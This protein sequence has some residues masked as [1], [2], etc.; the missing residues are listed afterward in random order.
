MKFGLALL[1][2]LSLSMS[3]W[4]DVRPILK[5]TIETLKFDNCTEKMGHVDA[6][7]ASLKPSDYQSELKQSGPELLGVELWDF[8]IKVHTLLREFHQKG[9]LARDCANAYRGALRAIRYVE[10]L[11][12]EHQ[13]RINGGEFPSNAFV[14]GN[15]HVKR[16]PKFKDFDMI[17][18]LKSGDV[19][20][21]RG[22]AYTSAAIAS[23]GEFDT[24]FSHMSLVYIDADK[25]VWTVEA[26]IEVGSF[27]RPIEDH[28]KDNNFRTM[29][30]RFDDEKLAAKAAELMFIKVRDASKKTGNILYDFGFDMKENNS[31]FCSEIVSYGFSLASD[32]KLQIPLYTSRLMLRKPS[33][34]KNLGITEDESFIPADI[35][36]DPRFQII[37]EWRDAARVQDNHEKDAILHA[38]F[39][40]ADEFDYRM[41]QGSS[42]TSR[43]Y[44]NVVWP[45]RRVPILK[46]YFKDKLPINMSRALIGYFGVLEST[47]EMLHKELKAANGKAITARSLPLLREESHKVLDDLRINDAAQ[48]K[49]KMHQMYRPL[50]PKEMKD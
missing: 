36:V 34:V 24:Q 49:P 44:R 21:T 10:D 17:K 33:F 42:K 46:R 45:L 3:V 29:I 40:W 43:L 23:L 41:I 35:E 26:H 15:L 1:T 27:V 19:I 18:D 22:N 13:Y 25:K 7:L 37:A 32:S 6:V 50:D 4:A 5:E 14:A 11:V 8:K 9:S 31:L 39:E 47:A 38:M 30:F 2:L 48:R 20:L 28:I 12:Q 16:A